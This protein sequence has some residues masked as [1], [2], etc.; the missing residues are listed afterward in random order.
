MGIRIKRY[1]CSCETVIS[2]MK[3]SDINATQYEILR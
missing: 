2:E 1:L 3:V